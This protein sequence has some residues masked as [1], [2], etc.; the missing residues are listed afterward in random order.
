MWFLVKILVGILRFLAIALRRNDRLASFRFDTLH[1]GV[2]IVALVGK[3]GIGLVTLKKQFRLRD[4]R[5]LSG[6]Q[7]QFHGQPQA[8]DGRMKL[9]G[10][11]PSRAAQRL[12]FRPYVGTPFFAPAACGWARMTVLSSN[13]H[14]RSASW[15]SRKMRSQMPFADQRSKRFHTDFQLPNR[16][17]RSRH[18][19]PAS[20]SQATPPTQTR[21][22][23]AVTP[24][25]PSRPGK[26]SLIRSQ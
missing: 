16:S 17:G 3:D 15:S 26:K 14:S 12:M 22:S 23:L 8:V 5:L 25:S 4:I 13:S 24:G 2:C 19:D 21:L 1:Q 9:R 6:S 18:G 10:K 11:T 20:S 7:A